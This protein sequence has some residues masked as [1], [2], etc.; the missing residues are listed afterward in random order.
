[1]SITLGTEKTS[2]LPAVCVSNMY[3]GQSSNKD[4]DVRYLNQI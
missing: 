3:V 1:M 4:I 2:N